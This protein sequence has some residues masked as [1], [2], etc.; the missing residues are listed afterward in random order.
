[1]ST[2]ASKILVVA[3]IGAGGGTGAAVARLFAKS[4]YNVA[5]IARNTDSLNKLSEDI[6]QSG[7]SAAP[8]PVRNYSGPEV[9]SAFAAIRRQWPGVPIR[10]AVWNA[11]HAVWDAFLNIKDE[12]VEKTAEGAF[13]GPIS[14]S[15]ESIKAFQQQDLDE[16][17]SRGTLIF[18]GATAATRGNITT[19]VFAS[20]K[21]ASRALS[22]SL[23]KEFGKQNIH[24]V[25]AII[26]G[27]IA[28]DR[29]AGEEKTN[30]DKNLYPEAI[31][32]TY[33]F[34][35]RQHRSAW[36]WELDLR[37]AHEKW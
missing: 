22:Q 21:F 25:H 19:S 36:T 14:F 1:M 16:Q 27:S 23:A 2:L 5:L 30:P 7:G 32:E 33:E 4:G 20:G 8:F 17:G 6:Q 11:G 18:T 15:R 9:S 35:S 37:P 10:T 26:D 31:A 34:L 12:D 28:T 13:F 24:V 3:G 29:N